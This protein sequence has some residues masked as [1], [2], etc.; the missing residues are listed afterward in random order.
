MLSVD[1]LFIHFF[2]ITFP[3]LVIVREARSD[4]SRGGR[5]GGRGSGTGR[6]RGRGGSGFNRDFSNDENSFA[7]HAGQGALDGESGRERSG[8]GGPRGPYRGGRGGRGGFGDGEAG[9]N[10]QPRRVY[11]RRSGTGRG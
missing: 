6:G 2:F 8:Y 9:E 4:S 7:P 11:E 10:G 5:G 1:L 3:L